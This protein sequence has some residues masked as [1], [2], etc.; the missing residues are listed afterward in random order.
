MTEDKSKPNPDYV[1]PPDG[2]VVG[3]TLHGSGKKIRYIMRNGRVFGEIYV[4]K[5]RKW[6]S[7]GWEPIPDLS[8]LGE[9][10][11]P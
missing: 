4:P 3:F 1:T 8:C 10:C 9:A 5:T 11:D 7:H 6:K 2:T